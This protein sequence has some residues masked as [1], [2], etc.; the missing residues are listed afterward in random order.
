[1][2]FYKTRSI[3]QRLEYI[4]NWQSRSVR[5]YDNRKPDILLKVHGSGGSRSR[6]A[7]IFKYLRA[8]IREYMPASSPRMSNPEPEDRYS[9][10]SISV[11]EYYNFGYDVVDAWAEKEP[12]R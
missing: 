5:V 8:S 3:A 1:M 12:G 9:S 6:P 4:N 10:F 11:P 7:E 2:S